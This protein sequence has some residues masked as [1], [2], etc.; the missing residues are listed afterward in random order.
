LGVGRP[1]RRDV[2]LE[3]DA[4]KAQAY[5]ERAL[6]IGR[7]QQARSWE[8]HA[9]LARLWQ[10]QHKHAKRMTSSRRSTTGLLRAS[11]LSM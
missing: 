9:S 2:G 3:R 5:F 11:T 4:A 6:E 1:A 8:L 10:D 7:A